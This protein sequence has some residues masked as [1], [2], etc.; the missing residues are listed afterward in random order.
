MVIPTKSQHI[1][2]WSEATFI[3]GTENVSSQKNVGIDPNTFEVLNGHPN[4]IPTDKI[5][6]GVVQNCREYT[7]VC[8]CVCICV[9]VFPSLALGDHLQACHRTHHLSPDPARN[10]LSLLYLSIFKPFKIFQP[11]YRLGD[12][13]IVAAEIWSRAKEK[14]AALIPVR[15]CR[16]R[17][18]DD[19]TLIP[20]LWSL[21]RG[22]QRC[23]WGCNADAVSFILLL[24]QLTNTNGMAK[25][26]IQLFQCS[27]A[28]MN[29]TYNT[30]YI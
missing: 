7:S 10:L 11:R 9:C 5:L 19:K 25:N 17:V 16:V 15:G 4:K 6:G 20:C 29:N 21:F 30:G 22:C 23:W 14:R 18:D 28:C 27:S 12:P 2:L 24:R 1:Y 26:G 3:F 13:R 8:V